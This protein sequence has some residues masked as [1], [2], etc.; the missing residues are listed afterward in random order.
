MSKFKI[1]III[2][3]FNAGKT[4]NYL[5]ESIN[6]Q[7]K[8][9]AFEV[10]F[11]D[12]GSDDGSSDLIESFFEGE[13][14]FEYRILHYTKKQ[15]SYAARNFGVD[16]SEGEILAFTD[17][18]C[19]LRQDYIQ[20]V[21]NEFSSN[22]SRRIVISGNIELM[23]EN[24][25][26]IWENFDKSSFLQNKSSHLVNKVATANLVVHRDA[27]FQVGYFLEVQSTGDSEWSQRSVLKGKSIEFHPDILVYHPTRKTYGEIKKKFT[28]LG[29]G[30]GQRWERGKLL[31]ILFYFLKIFNYK[32]N[33]VISRKIFRNVGFWGV[34]KF[35]FYF[36]LLRVC[37][38]R[39]AV[40]GFNSKF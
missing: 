29:Y 6:R 36:H 26:N 15:S 2:P 14:D 10:L 8:K 21:L 31:L 1:S 19:I 5:L 7:N 23:V 38:L 37:Q 18:D 28:R 4:I 25:R 24:P 13:P 22:E 17:A 33:F 40:K 11:V 32:T 34:L 16:H 20:N 35:N 3:F 39:F 27:F 12:N 30:N 9:D